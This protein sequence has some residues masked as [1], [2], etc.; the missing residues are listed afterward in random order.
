MDHEELRWILAHELAHVR[1]RDHVIRWIE[2]LTCC[3]F[4]W[5]PV[6]WWAR[7]QLRAEEEFCCDAL[8]L[9]SFGS[10]PRSYA[11][12]LVSV[13]DFLST[14]PTLRAPAFASE[15]DSGGRSNVIERRLKLIV[16]NNRIPTTPRWLRAARM[17]AVLILPL[18]L[19]YCGPDSSVADPELSLVEGVVQVYEGDVPTK[20]VS[21]VPE[22][23]S[24][25]IR[26][27][28][29]DEAFLIT[30]DFQLEG[31]HVQFGDGL[32]LGRDRHFL[33]LAQPGEEP[34]P[35]LTSNYTAMVPGSAECP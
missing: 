34:D 24:L 13:I 7:R 16:S 29:E 10:S 33:Q 30:G 5:N 15:A 21:C 9:S 8:V 1:R 31:G 26:H 35:L 27:R 3:V 20:F 14:P 2:W 4:W 25:H 23:I 18:G 32:D 11:S 17:T 22:A 19:I 6:A 28:L 12:S